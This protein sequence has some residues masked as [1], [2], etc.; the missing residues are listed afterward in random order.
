MNEI[1]RTTLSLRLSIDCPF[2]LFVSDCPAVRESLGFE[3]AIISTNVYAACAIIRSSSRHGGAPIVSR[4]VVARLSSP[5]LGAS[6]I[7][8]IAARACCMA[9]AFLVFLSNDIKSSG[10][11][12]QFIRHSEQCWT[13]L[14][15]FELPQI[16][17]LC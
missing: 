9:A 7:F 2:C 4:F 5:T 1:A 12:D 8:A 14:R 15:Q 17:P 13:T 10:P 16:C 3:A 11:K 6:A